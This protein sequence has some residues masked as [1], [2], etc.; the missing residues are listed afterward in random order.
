VL[1]QTAPV[2]TQF[3]ADFLALQQLIGSV[4]GSPS[5]C[6]RVSA[7]GDLVQ[8]TTTGLAV[9]RPD[10][11]AVF[12]AGNDHWALTPSGLQQWSGNW[13]NGLYPLSTPEPAIDANPSATERPTHASVEPMLLIRVLQDGSNTI[14]VE[15]PA[16]SMF[17]VE[18]ADGC[19]D[20]DAAVGDHVFVRSGGSGIDLILVQQHETCAIA[21]MSTAPGD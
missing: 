19:P 17:T 5:G 12:A 6:P 16:G 4:M 20:V 10:G 8:V 2:C 1:A 18:T 15:D 9:H 13:H 14:V 7:N 3:A 11:M 21:G